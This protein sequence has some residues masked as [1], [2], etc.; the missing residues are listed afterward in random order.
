MCL[1]RTKACENYTAFFCVV[2]ERLS[3]SI[4]RIFRSLYERKLALFAK[5]F[6]HKPSQNPIFA[7]SHALSTTNAKKP[8]HENEKPTRQHE[9]QPA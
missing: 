7:R 8:E 9:T 2:Y 5:A 1:S 4:R 6:A 3:Q